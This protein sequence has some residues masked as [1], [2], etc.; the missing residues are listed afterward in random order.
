MTRVF[1]IGPRTSKLTEKQLSW[2]RVELVRAMGRLVQRHGSL[3]ALVSLAPGV[4][5]LWWEAARLHTPYVKVESWVVHPDH[6]K[7]WTQQRWA[8]NNDVIKQSDSFRVSFSTGH[9]EPQMFH[10]HVHMMAESCDI[11]VI[12]WD[13]N[14]D[15][16]AIAV[17]LESARPTFWIDPAS[18]RVQW[19]PEGMPVLR[20]QEVA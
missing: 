14:R 1:A 11:Q 10:G 13:G 4:G 19:M 12:V 17:A 5:R 2:V 16:Y 20:V 18:L 7:T 6:E 15:E 8:F 9:I 3:N